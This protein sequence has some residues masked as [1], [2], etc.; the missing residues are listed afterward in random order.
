MANA[1]KRR[2]AMRAK[3][4]VRQHKLSMMGISGVIVM[5][6][7]V[8]MFGSASL[9]KE[10]REKQAE[11]DKLRNQIKDEDF[12]SQELDEYEAYFGT[13]EYIENQAKEMWGLTYPN[14]SIVKQE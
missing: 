14:E 9:S 6:A 12:Y 4:R 7:A 10:N 8:L 3:R 1:R 5:L 2:R 11:E 13:R